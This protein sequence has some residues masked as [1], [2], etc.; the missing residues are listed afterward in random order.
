MKRVFAALAAALLCASGS[1]AVVIPVPEPDQSV[2]EGSVLPPKL[3]AFRL[4]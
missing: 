1:S 3:S 2:I 4:F